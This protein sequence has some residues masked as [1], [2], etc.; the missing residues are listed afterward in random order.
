VIAITVRQPWAALIAAGAKRTENRNWR[1]ESIIGKPLAIHAG[2]YLPT[3]EDIRKA[4]RLARRD[5]DIDWESAKRVLDGAPEEWSHGCVVAVCI[6]GEPFHGEDGLWRWPLDEVRIATSRPV[7]GRP[8]LFSI[9][10][11]RVRRRPVQ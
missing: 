3:D 6:V 8:G 7:S 9:P 10:S 5:R 4:R 11:V 1:S 2:K